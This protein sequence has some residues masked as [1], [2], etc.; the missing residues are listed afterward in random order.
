MIRLTT[1]GV[2][3][4]GAFAVQAQV[5]GAL[6]IYWIDVEG[7]AAT[8]IVT[9]DRES[10]LM[11][12]GWDTDDDRDALRIVAAMN[13]AGVTAIDYFIT[14]HFHRDH[15]SGLPALARRVTIGQYVDHGDSVEL[16]S[17]AGRS[18]WETYRTTAADKRR[19]VVPGDRLPLTG[20]DFTFVTSNRVLLQQALR[21]PTA[22]PHCDDASAGEEFTGENPSS[23]GYVLALGEFEFV[24]LGDL[25]VDLQHRLVCPRNLLGEIDLLQVP[26]HG[27]GVATQLTR[28]LAPTAA[29]L[30][31]GPRKGGS[32]EG[33]E[34][35]RTVPDIQ[36]IWQSHRALGTDDAHNA[37]ARMTANLTEDNDAGHWVK[38][39]VRADGAEYAIVNGRNGYRETYKTK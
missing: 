9:P 17:A 13:D 38:A 7:G 12:A 2:L 10:V 19:S 37:A 18:L 22:N 8:L 1:F 21:A 24:N 33:F 4:L 5:P 35:I 29:V 30:N 20:V 26:H 11:D 3:C 6:E 15:V 34:A 36:G 39:T 31:N 28:A 16:D 25:T 32:P 14:S 23:V 27:N